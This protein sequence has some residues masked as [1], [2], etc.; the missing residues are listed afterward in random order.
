MAKLDRLIRIS[1]TPLA[2]LIAASAANADTFTISFTV[3]GFVGAPSPL[4][5][6]QK[7]LLAGLL[8]VDRI[9]GGYR[10]SGGSRFDGDYYR[11]CVYVGRSLIQP[12]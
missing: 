7:F 11:R 10:R 12:F 8:Q 3:S 5:V 9:E 2:L 6:P 4:T 1:T